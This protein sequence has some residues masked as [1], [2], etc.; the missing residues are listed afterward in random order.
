MSLDVRRSA[1]EAICSAADAR[2]PGRRREGV[3]PA[4]GGHHCGVLMSWGSNVG[5]RAHAVDLPGDALP[6]SGSHRERVARGEDQR[7]PDAGRSRAIQSWPRSPTPSQRPRRPCCYVLFGVADV[8]PGGRTP[9]DVLRSGETTADAM[10]ETL[11][12]VLG[13]AASRMRSLGLVRGPADLLSLYCPSPDVPGVAGEILRSCVP[14]LLD[15]LARQRRAS[16]GPRA[17]S[18]RPAPRPHRHLGGLT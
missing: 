14:P 15:G 16:A 1:P 2:V 9:D 4:L 13:Q 18:R 8:P 6:G 11:Q 12:F 10:R 3:S 5:G 17:R 7:R